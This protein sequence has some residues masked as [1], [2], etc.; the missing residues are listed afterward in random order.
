MSK[1][2]Q[3]LDEQLHLPLDWLQKLFLSSTCPCNGEA[4]NR[5][6][7][8]LISEH[9]SGKPRQKCTIGLVHGRG[10]AASEF[11]N[12]QIRTLGADAPDSYGQGRSSEMH[13]QQPGISTFGG[14]GARGRMGI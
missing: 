5:L 6:I 10:G 13:M 3:Q 14:S 11:Y 7:A 2:W 4:N 8:A 1:T 12:D 9:A